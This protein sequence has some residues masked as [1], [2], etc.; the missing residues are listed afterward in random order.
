[1]QGAPCRHHWTADRFLVGEN[2]NLHHF[3]SFTPATGSFLLKHGLQERLWVYDCFWQNPDVHLSMHWKLWGMIPS[4]SISSSQAVIFPKMS[5]GCATKHLESQGDQLS[6][7]SSYVTSKD[8]PQA[9]RA[10]LR[11]GNRHLVEIK[12]A[13]IR[14]GHAFTVHQPKHTRNEKTHKTILSNYKCC[15]P[16]VGVL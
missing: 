2:K 16:L 11:T 1:M 5:A 3:G 13:E 12:C 9:C 14:S 8:L 4:T 7:P 15:S 10:L 6:L